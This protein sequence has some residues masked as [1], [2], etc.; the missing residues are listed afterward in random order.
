MFLINLVVEQRSTSPYKAQV[1][2]KGMFE[3]KRRPTYVVCQAGLPN[4]MFWKLIYGQVVL[5]W[6]YPSES[7]C[8]TKFLLK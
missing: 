3:H 5:L 8:C 6:K 7:I 4:V 1:L 2:L